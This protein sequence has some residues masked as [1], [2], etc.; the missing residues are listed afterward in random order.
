MTA[1]CNKVILALSCFALCN[2][3][4]AQSEK[5]TTPNETVTKT[6]TKPQDPPPEAALDWAS[7]FK[8]P[9]NEK[10]R[11][12]LETKLLKWDGTRSPKDL[13]IKGQSELALGQLLAAEAT[14]RE[15]M[16][17]EPLNLE[18]PLDLAQVYLRQKQVSKAFDLLAEL[19][20]KLDKLEATD[21]T[22]VFRYRYTLGMAFLAKG[23]HP[24][25]HAI[26]SDLIAID[27]TFAPAYAALASSYLTINKLS[28]ADFI[29]KKGLDRC[30]ED[31]S[32]Y[33]MLGV[34]AAKRKDSE[35][36]LQWYNK[37]L[38]LSPTF[39]PALVNRA[40]LAIS[41]FEFDQATEDL[42]KAIVYAPTNTEALVSLAICQ[43]RSKKVDAAKASLMRALDLDPANAPA[44][45]NLGVLFAED[46]KKPD[47]AIR[48][49]QEVL[50]IE[51]ASLEIKQ[52][53]KEFISDFRLNRQGTSSAL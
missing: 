9:P 6:S 12:E 14:F 21:S 48:Y 17:I 18:A 7:F 15:I 27:K 28:S 34:I 39:V 41:R 35:A 26:L 33:N 13:L 4:S 11:R 46:Y 32:L 47:E 1:L 51:D 20:K 44:R 40:N 42:S 38:A 49:F 5:N 3:F 52:L 2:C 29:A 24:Q 22:F 23:D 36:A 45:F 43:K 19:N 8:G 53:S 30:K 10:E 25:G 16:R 50:L 31:P 37:A